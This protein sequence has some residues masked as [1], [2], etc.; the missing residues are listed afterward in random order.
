MLT[1]FFRKSKPINYVLIA[2]LMTLLYL[3]H[4]LRALTSFSVVEIFKNI[5]LLLV[6]I[7]T[8]LLID[9]IT[10][11][12]DLTKRN[13]FVVFLFA[14][15]VGTFPET[16][17]N[18]KVLLAH[19]F[20]LLALRRIISLKSKE[21]IQKKLVDAAI[22]I[23]IASFIYFWCILFMGFL[24]VA[25]FSFTDRNHKKYVIPV[26][27]FATVW[28]LYNAYSILF[29]NTLF[30]PTNWV[31]TVGFDFQIYQNLQA[32]LPLLLFIA[33]L[34]LSIFFIFLGKKNTN[35]RRR[36]T[37]ALMAFLTIFA[38]ALLIFTAQKNSAE[39]LFMATPFAVITA[40]FFE[41]RS[42]FAFKEI[43]MWILVVLPLMRLFL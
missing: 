19:G 17:L 2:V 29:H 1:S 40:N 36:K 41:K 26:V 32:G 12:N 6:F 18:S 28:V 10:K 7:F 33:L 8:M 25:I 13:T 5:G 42:A 11:K 20:I 22:W 37:T 3:A 16:F 34:G 9:F 23:T 21:Q 38:L 14:I 35:K 31:E 15:F 4:T 27:G 39:L 30:L 24:Y 43:L